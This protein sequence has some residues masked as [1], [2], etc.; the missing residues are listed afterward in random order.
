MDGLA[1]VRAYL[2]DVL[3]ATK[4]SFDEHLEHLEQVLT[5]LQSAG[6]K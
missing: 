6:S 2:Y 1:F 5:R 3:I 4:N